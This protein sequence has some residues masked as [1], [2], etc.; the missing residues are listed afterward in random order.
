MRTLIIAEAGINHNGS[1]KRAF[2][3][4]DAAKY[5]GADIVKFQIAIP[6]EVM[7]P[8]ASKANYQKR[9]NQD[10]ETQLQMVSRILININYFSRIKNYCIKKKIKFLCSPFDE[11]SLKE[12]IKLK[13]DTIKIPSGEITNVPLLEKIGKS[14]K[15]IILSTGMS[16]LKEILGAIKILTKHGTKRKNIS[17]LHCNTA[18]PS[19]FEDLNLGSIKILKKKLKL[20]IGYSDHSIGIE[21]SIAAV[22]YGAEIIEKHLTINNNLEGPD[23][24]A[25]LNPKD[26]KKMVK[27]IRNIE[28]AKGHLIGKTKSE[29]QNFRIVR[30]SIVAIKDIKIGEKFTNSNIGCKRPMLGIPAERWHKVLNKKSKK[31]YKKNQFI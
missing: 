14:G 1:I 13:V 17:V 27:C 5:S 4:I 9:N 8:N 19:P 22:A 25:S 10:K 12:L 29:K 30:R 11:K 28:K 3:L 16:K 7:I 31:N 2:K 20:K 24:K 21:G 6:E 18:Y 23:H 26:F 15:R